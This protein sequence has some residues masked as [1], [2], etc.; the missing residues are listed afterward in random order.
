MEKFTYLQNLVTGKAS[1][2]IDGLSLTSANYHVAL[3]ILKSKFGNE[4]VTIDAH[5]DS[6]LSLASPTAKASDLSSF[7]DK[8]EKHIRCLEALGLKEEEFA[9]TLVPMIRKKIARR[10]QT[11]IES[12]K[13]K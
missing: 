6:I 13:S 9:K 1:E 5:F 10:N 12:Q 8:L 11:G 7:Y 2:A 4:Q 3:G